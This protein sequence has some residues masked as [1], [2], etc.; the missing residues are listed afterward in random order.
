MEDGFEVGEE[1]EEGNEALRVTV[2]AAAAQDGAA[3]IDRSGAC[4]VQRES[5]AD[6]ASKAVAASAAEDYFWVV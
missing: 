5:S 3:K 1:E 6:D 2:E 4:G